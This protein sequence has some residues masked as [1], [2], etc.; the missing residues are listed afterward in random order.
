MSENEI[1]TP[2][3]VAEIFR[4]QTKTVNRWAKRDRIPSFR[5]LGGHYRFRRSDI[6]QA[7]ATA[8]ERVDE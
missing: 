3:E 4:V 1:L 2:G 8:D 7:L 5:T 6:E